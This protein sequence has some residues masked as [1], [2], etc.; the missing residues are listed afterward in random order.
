MA[1]QNGARAGA[2]GS[3]GRSPLPLQCTSHRALLNRRDAVHHLF[4]T[5]F[6]TSSPALDAPITRPDNWPP[7]SSMPVVRLPLMDTSE[8]TATPS[9]APASRRRSGRQTRVPEKFQPEITIAPKR[10]RGEH[11]EE[12]DVENHDPE[13]EEVD[14][15]SSEDDAD[16]S[17][18]EEER[19]KPKKKRT[20][21]QQSRAKK[22]ATKKPK[23]NGAGPGA[24][25]ITLGLP[26][27]PKAKKSVR[28]M[29]GDRRDGDGVY[30]E[31]WKY[32]GARTTS[33]DTMQRTYSDLAILQTM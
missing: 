20:A 11:D 13:G 4:I 17:P 33:I 6:P 21:S 3:Q 26:S 12:D 14:E 30:G 27:R 7:I 23:I 32:L 8:N 16:D 28:V 22:P 15:E 10:K 19:A 9:P 1:L 24:A 25:S 31:L 2:S 5:T 29:T 18:A